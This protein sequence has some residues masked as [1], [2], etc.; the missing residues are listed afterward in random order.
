M[1]FMRQAKTTSR[2]EIPERAKNEAA[3]ILYHQIVNLVEK[4]QIPSSMFTN[5]DQTPLKYAPVSNPLMAQNRSKHVAIE[6]S[7]YKNAITATFG[8]TC[9]NQFLPIQLIYGGKTLQSLPRFEFPKAFLLST[10]KKHFGNSTESLKFIDEISIP[11]VSSQRKRKEL[12]VNHPALLFTDVFKWQVMD[13]VLLKL[14]ENTIFLARV[15]PNTTNFFR[16]LDRKQS[17]KS[18]IKEKIYRV[19]Q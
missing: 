19:V 12:D 8:I 16:P 13:P 17:Y 5:I 14:R 4:H 15:S 3:L 9:D 6:G 2:S 7:T 11:Y 10:K 1:G 18:L